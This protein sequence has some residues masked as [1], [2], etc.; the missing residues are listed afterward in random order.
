MCSTPLP[1]PSV[2][3]EAAPVL[4]FYPDLPGIAINTLYLLQFTPTQLYVLR[5]PDTDVT[6]VI[7]LIATEVRHSKAI[8]IL[9]INVIYGSSDAS[10]IVLP[11]TWE[12][13]QTQKGL[14]F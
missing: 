4:G 6:D 11:P 13:T 7:Y 5:G 3:D 10:R 2:W 1:S 8:I 9:K 14:L 12:H